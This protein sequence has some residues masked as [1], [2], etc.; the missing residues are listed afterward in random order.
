MVSWPVTAVLAALVACVAATSASSVP[1]S[2]GSNPLDALEGR[3]VLVV[4]PK[5]GAVL[6]SD[7]VDVKLTLARAVLR[8][9]GRT[10]TICMWLDGVVR[11]HARGLAVRNG[12]VVVRGTWH[13]SVVG[14]FC[15]CAGA[16]AVPDCADARH[17]A[18]AGTAHPQCQYPVSVVM[19]AA[20]VCVRASVEAAVLNPGCV[21]WPGHD[22]P[23]QRHER[24][25]LLGRLLVHGAR[26]RRVS[27]PIFGHLLVCG[28]L[29]SL[30]ADVHW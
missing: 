20:C 11:T 13:V 22:R 10:P 19:N 15:C 5:N 9:A 4:H 27:L 18:H 30:A 16:A 24:R 17:E 1:S 23:S 26:C 6:T 8:A 3:P 28:C 12:P 21:T 2:D 25:V 14:S 7:H 29:L